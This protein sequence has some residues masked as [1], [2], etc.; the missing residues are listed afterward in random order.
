M[1]DIKVTDEWLDKYMSVLDEAI[2]SELEQ[3]TDYEYSFSD[4]FEHKM[5]RLVWKEAHPEMDTFFQLSKRVA[6]FAFCIIGYLFLLKAG[7]EESR[8]RHLEMVKNMIENSQEDFV[9]SMPEYAPAEY[10][11]VDKII[12]LYGFSVVYKD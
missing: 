8:S 9:Y 5:K 10:Q 12:P 3:K 1:E 11:E 2:I 7:V 4:K 6:V